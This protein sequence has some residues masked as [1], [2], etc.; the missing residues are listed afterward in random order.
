[1]VSVADVLHKN[2]R[3]QKLSSFGNFLISTVFK[4]YFHTT[5]TMARNSAMRRLMKELKTIQDEGPQADVILQIEDP[6]DPDGLYHWKGWICGPV[7][8]PYEGGQ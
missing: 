6:N 8:T 7:D 5:T 1:M 4:N 3:Q 2:N